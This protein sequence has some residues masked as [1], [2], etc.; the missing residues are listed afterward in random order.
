MG[1]GYRI[2]QKK[3]IFSSGRNCWSGLD[4]FYFPF[5]SCYSGN[6]IV[7]LAVLVELIVLF[8][9]S[10]KLI[11]NLYVFLFLITHNRPFAISIVTL[12]LFPGTVVH[13]LSH[14]FTAEILGVRTG[15]LSLAPESIREP[16]IQAGMVMI[17]KTDPFRKTI[18]GLAPLLS[19][20]ACI[21]ALAYWLIKP[22]LSQY[23][24]FVIMYLLFAI[25]NSMFPS[26][27][28]MEGTPILFITI[29]LLGI[30]AYIAGIRFNLSGK[31]LEVVQSIFS[32]LI[33]NLGF[34]LAVNIILLLTVS[35]LVVLT[36]K[37]LFRR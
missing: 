23:L 6:M 1:G 5:H 2:T 36:R 25:S 15:K 22:D 32:S 28:D 30:G 21:S 20:L 16:E 8:F 33:T 18:I 27:Q 14:L 12:V 24:L 7:N 29:A 3:F 13:E 34:V 19:G 35:V 10:K 9:L 4:S 31:A 37:L 17:A 11:Q 26:R